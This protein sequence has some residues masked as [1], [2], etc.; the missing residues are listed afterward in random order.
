MLFRSSMCSRYMSKIVGQEMQDINCYN[1]FLFL[2][3]KQIDNNGIPIKQKSNAK[4]NIYVKE[5]T[6]TS[7]ADPLK[8]HIFS[9]V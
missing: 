7:E 5:Q 2:F 4:K 3:D 1:V 9:E 8:A 6:F